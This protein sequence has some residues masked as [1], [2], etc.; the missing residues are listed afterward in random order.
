L[1]L[2]CSF[3]LDKKGTK[4]SSH[5]KGFLRTGLCAA[6]QAEPG[7]QTFR[8]TSFAQC[9]CFGGNLLCPATALATIVLPDPWPKL[10]C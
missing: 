1:P 7:L 10:F 2:G 9:P 4:K 6:A 5:Q 8:A 3:F